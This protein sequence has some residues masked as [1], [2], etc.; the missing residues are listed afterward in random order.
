[1]NENVWRAW[2]AQQPEGKKR[3]Y[4]EWAGEKVRTVAP[5]G[6]WQETEDIADMVVFLSSE[7]A[8]NV[9]GQTIRCG[10]RAGDA[11]VGR[12]AEDRE[13]AEGV[14]GEVGRGDGG[15]VAQARAVGGELLEPSLASGAKI[16]A[17]RS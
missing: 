2:N 12:L 7:R 15:C 11:L 1:M 8:R 17:M 4:G 5:L 13:A 14:G 10:W 9:T 16:S 6:R 3:P